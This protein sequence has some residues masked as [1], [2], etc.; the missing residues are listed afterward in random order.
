MIEKNKDGLL[1]KIIKGNTKDIISERANSMLNDIH[2]KFKHQ[3]DKFSQEIYSL[4]AEGQTAIQR[5][6]PTNTF[7][8]SYQADT[9][10]FVKSDIERTI[11]IGKMQ[12]VFDALKSRYVELFNKEYQ[13][14][15]NEF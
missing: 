2:I 4:K 12:Q 14:P 6:A 10:G 15:T 9:E 5:L 11:K 13:E 1:T 8:T 3:L 7:D